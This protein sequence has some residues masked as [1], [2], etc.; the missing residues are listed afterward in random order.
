MPA[1]LTPCICS[2]TSRSGS[3]GSCTPAQWGPGGSGP[4]R[5]LRRC[6]RVCAPVA[7]SRRTLASSASS[8]PSRAATILRRLRRRRPVRTEVRTVRVAGGGFPSGTPPSLVR[9][10]P[11]RSPCGSRFGV[12]PRPSRAGSTW[13]TMHPRTAA[14]YR[15]APN[16]SDFLAQRTAH[17]G[18]RSSARRGPRRLLGPRARRVAARRLACR[19]GVPGGASGEWRPPRVQHRGSMAAV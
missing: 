19:G 6:D 11:L 3:S 8:S 5:D 14:V 15:D 2:K 1:I 17:R 7:G 4:R 13:G 12:S 18:F 10:V 9:R 16:S